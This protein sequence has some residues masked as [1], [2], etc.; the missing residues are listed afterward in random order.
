MYRHSDATRVRI[1]LKN[2]TDKLILKIVDNGKGITEQEIANPNSFGIIGIRERALVLGGDVHIKGIQGKGTTIT[3]H[4]P[5]R[6]E[7]LTP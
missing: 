7:G 4:V 1:S 2:N 5:L 6:R 3:V